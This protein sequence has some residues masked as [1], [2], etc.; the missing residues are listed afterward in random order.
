MAE[1]GRINTLRVL[2]RAEHG[3]YLEGEEGND[4]LLPNKYVPEGTSITDEIDVF[5]YRDSE[6]RIIAT[7][8]TPKAMVGDFA[9][10]EAVAVTR[11]GAF[12]DWGLEKDLFVPFREQKNKMVVGNKYVVGVYLDESTDR[13]VASAKLGQFLADEH[14]EFDTNELVDVLVYDITEIGYKC[15]INN[16]YLGIIYKNEVFEKPLEIGEELEAY[17]VKVRGDGKT[18]LSLLRPGYEKMDDIS[19]DLLEELQDC[20]GYIAISD[21]SPAEM[22]YSRFGISKKNFKKAIGALYKQKIIEIEKIGIRLV[23]KKK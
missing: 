5:V 7:N 14:P 13:V 23:E 17:A 19:K 16:S 2:R 8:L 9:L 6:D 22:I 12:L 1:I 21:K 18:D 4:I 3:L 11:F 10:L 15:I 20:G